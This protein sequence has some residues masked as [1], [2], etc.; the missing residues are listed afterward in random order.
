MTRQSLM[1]QT[2]VLT[3]ALT[4]PGIRD[5]IRNWHF[6]LS[7]SALSTDH[8][9]LVDWLNQALDIPVGLF[10]HCEDVGFQF[11]KYQSGWSCESSFQKWLIQ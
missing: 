11:L 4:W 5:R 2:M 3:F 1:T 10:T 8:N 7:S 9:G 6:Y